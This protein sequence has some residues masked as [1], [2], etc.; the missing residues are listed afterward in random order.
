MAVTG[1]NT[2]VSGGRDVWTFG[3]ENEQ[4]GVAQTSEN[5]TPHHPSLSAV[6][7]PVVDKGEKANMVTKG[8]FLKLHQLLNWSLHQLLPSNNS[9]S[10]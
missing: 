8:T 2:G 10:E 6:H 7:L 3:G 5:N 9:H 1:N 4:T